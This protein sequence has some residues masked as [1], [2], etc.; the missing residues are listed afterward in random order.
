MSQVLSTHTGR[1][2]NAMFAENPRTS[3][4]TLY[5]FTRSLILSIQSL[6]LFTSINRKLTHQTLIQ[7]AYVFFFE[8]PHKN[9]NKNVILYLYLY[10]YLN[11]NVIL[12]IDTFNTS[13]MFSSIYIYIFYLILSFL[14]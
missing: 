1:S 2:L 8:K 14:C 6:R 12:Y 3:K 4:L 10:L 5:I 7:L 9:L 11:K 13:P